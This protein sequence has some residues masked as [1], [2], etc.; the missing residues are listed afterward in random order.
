MNKYSCIDR[1]AIKICLSYKHSTRGFQKP[2]SKEN[3]PNAQCSFP[4]HLH[5]QR[6]SIKNSCSFQRFIKQIIR[7][8]KS[9]SSIFS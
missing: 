2:D 6:M 1:T 7:K 4:Q 5:P 9:L 8:A 3:P